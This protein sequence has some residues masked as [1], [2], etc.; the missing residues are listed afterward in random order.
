MSCCYGTV[1]DHAEV[2]PDSKPSAKM[3]KRTRWRRGSCTCI[4]TR[5]RNSRGLAQY[6]GRLHRLHQDKT[7]VVVTESSESSDPVRNRQKCWSQHP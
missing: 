5:A 6:A 4:S 7:V 1:F 2:S 3:K